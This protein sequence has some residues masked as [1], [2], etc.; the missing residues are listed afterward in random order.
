MHHYVGEEFALEFGDF[1]V[2]LTLPAD[3]DDRH[4]YNQFI[5]RVERR[6]DLMAHLKE[7]G[8][9]CEIYYPV[10]LHL[11]E[12]FAYLGHGQG[13]FPESERAARE[14][15]AIPIYPELS[16]EQA[17]AVVESIAGFYS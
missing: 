9:G 5:L 6:D 2:R 16:D 13:D 12:C 1:Q 14:T 3:T 11:Q 8:I 4:I 10:P 17:R 15:L 7:S